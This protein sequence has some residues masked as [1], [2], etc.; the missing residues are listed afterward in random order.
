MSEQSRHAADTAS[1]RA[2]WAI[3][4][5]TLALVICSSAA[6]WLFLQHEKKTLPE[7]VFDTAIESGPPYLQAHPQADLAE[8]AQA[9][10]AQLHSVGW[11]DQQRGIVHMPVE[12]AMQLL[13]QRG[14]PEE[15]AP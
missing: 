11:I 15:D 2:L 5:G 7:T 6:I 12:Q 8:Y 4:L 14:L 9:A 13:V 1:A 10:A 3:M